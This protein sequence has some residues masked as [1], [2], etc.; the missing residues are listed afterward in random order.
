[1]FQT[2]PQWKSTW[3]TFRV[4]FEIVNFRTQNICVYQWNECVA[5]LTWQ[6]VKWYKLHSLKED[7][8]FRRTSVDVWCICNIK[9]LWYSK[10]N[11]HLSLCLYI[12]PN[13]LYRNVWWIFE[14]CSK[15]F[16]FYSNLT[17]NWENGLLASLRQSVR[18][19]GRPSPCQH[20]TNLL[21]LGGDLMKFVWKFFGDLSRIFSNY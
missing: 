1:M 19:S 8:K 3:L 16:I 17:K 14:N 13:I 10:Y 6:T 2:I 18:P 4:I 12:E 11:V 5:V 9:K 21:Q 7:Q 15:N 20:E